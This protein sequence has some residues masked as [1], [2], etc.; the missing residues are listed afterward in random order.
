[1]QYVACLPLSEALEATPRS[2][3]A[4][5]LFECQ[6]QPGSCEEWSA[7]S[8]GNAAVIT[9][10]SDAKPLAPPSGPTFLSNGFALDFLACVDPANKEDVLQNYEEVRTAPGSRM[11][12]KAGGEPAWIQNDETPTCGCGATMSFVAQLEE[13]AEGLNFGCGTAYAFVCKHCRENAKFLW[14]C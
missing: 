10:L 6:Q 8:G 13:C 1:M 14:Q 2:E 12:G 9:S 5:L 3:I 11:V 7:N 4:L